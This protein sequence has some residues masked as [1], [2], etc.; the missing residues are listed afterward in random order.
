[1]QILQSNF[2]PIAERIAADESEARGCRVSG[3]NDI[4]SRA[5]LEKIVCAAVRAS[6]GKIV[7][8]H[9][10]VDAIRAL[11]EMLGYENEQPHGND[12]GFVTS[13]NRF[14]NRAEAYRLHFSERTEPDELQSDDL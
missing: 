14:V 3:L 4:N 12:Q 11:Q 10:H 5:A 2:G 13:A 1:M 8:G 9:R 7:T 6:N